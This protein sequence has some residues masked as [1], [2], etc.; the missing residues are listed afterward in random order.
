MA[1]LVKQTLESAM[2]TR[3]WR[4]EFH[5]PLWPTYTRLPRLRIGTWRC[6]AR[7]LVSHFATD[8]RRAKTEAA[9]RGDC[10]RKHSYRSRSTRAAVSGLFGIVYVYLSLKPICMFCRELNWLVNV[11]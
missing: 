4:A 5:L 6:A 7:V 9:R 8:V 11:T 10:T 2:L 1:A 3:P